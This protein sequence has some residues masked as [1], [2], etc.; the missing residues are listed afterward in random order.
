MQQK[1]L[2]TDNS[3][4]INTNK[5]AKN[6]NMNKNK[7]TNPKETCHIHVMPPTITDEDIS[8]LLNGIIGVMRRK[9]ELE[10]Q[11]ELINMN[12]NINKLKKE[13]KEKSAECIRLKNEIILLKSNTN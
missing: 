3:R 8:A 9:I 7:D 2:K 10:T 6:K 13:L 12:I 4:T 1:I 11:A 5:F